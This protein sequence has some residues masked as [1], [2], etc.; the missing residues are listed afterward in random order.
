MTTEKKSLPYVEV[1][2]PE[3]RKKGKQ[4][5][6]FG[7]EQAVTPANDTIQRF[8]AH[9]DAAHPIRGQDKLIVQVFQQRLRRHETDARCNQFYG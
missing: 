2:P 8:L 4:F 6:L 1:K 7:R 3:N 9:G 5:L